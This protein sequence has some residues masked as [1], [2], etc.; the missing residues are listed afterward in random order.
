M[1]K[2]YYFDKETKEYIGCDDAMLD[3]LETEITGKNVY[4]LPAFGTFKK[5]LEE[6]DGHVSVWDGKKWIYEE[7]NRNVEYWSSD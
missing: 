5:P 3:P 7:D 1:K 4:L 2:I 6:K